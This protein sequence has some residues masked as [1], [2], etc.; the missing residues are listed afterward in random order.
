MNGIWSTRW[1]LFQVMSNINPKWDSYQPLFSRYWSQ[2][3]SYP[4]LGFDVDIIM[5]DSNAMDAKDS[6]NDRVRWVRWVRWVRYLNEW[7]P[8]SLAESESN[9]RST[10]VV[11][12]T[13]VG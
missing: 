6:R 5:H 3:V 7:C 2:H 13:K 9:T 8:L 12:E 10:M 4:D 1:L 11:A